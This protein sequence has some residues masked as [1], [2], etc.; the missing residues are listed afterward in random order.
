MRNKLTEVSKL[1]WNGRPLILASFEGE[2][3]GRDMKA[4]SDLS[5]GFFLPRIKYTV[6]IIFS[7]WCYIIGLYCVFMNCAY[8]ITTR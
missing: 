3:K 4:V 5:A 6:K 7:T 1:D 8:A 2:A